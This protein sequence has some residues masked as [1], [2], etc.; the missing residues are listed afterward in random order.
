LWDRDEPRYAQCSRQMFQ[1]GDWIVP[2][3]YDAPR[4]NKPPLIYWCQAAAMRVFGHE[5]DAGAFAAR[6][7]SSLAMLCTLAILAIVITRHAGAEQ[8]FWTVLVFGSSGLTIMAA[9]VCLTDSVLLLFTMIAQLCL[10]AIW[11]GSRSWG[12]VT[13][14][15][16]ALGLGGLTKGPFIL[17]VVACTAVALAAFHFLDNFIHRRAARGDARE[18]E[19]VMA[20][21]NAGAERLGGGSPSSIDSTVRTLSEAPRELSGQGPA[22]R[23]FWLSV[24]QILLGVFIVLA[25]VVPWIL[26]VHHREPNFLGQMF[27]EAKDHLEEGKEG[28]HFPPGYHLVVV[29][30]DFMPWSLLLPMAIGIGIGNWRIPQARFA[31]AAVIGPWVMVEFIGTKLP[32]YLLPAL[33]PLAFLAAWAIRDCISGKARDMQSRLFLIGAGIWASVV[34]CVG[35]LPWWMARTFRPQPWGAMIVLT[36]GALLLAIAV[37]WLFRERRAGPALATTGLGMLALCAAA[38]TLFLPHAAYLQTSK[39][40]ANDLLKAGATHKGEVYMV[41]YKEPSLAFYQGGTLRERRR[42]FLTP[43]HRAEW[44]HWLAV[45]AD[46]WNEAAPD[47]RREYREIAREKGWAYS[48]QARVVEILVVEKIGPVKTAS[49]TAK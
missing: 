2:R 38:C 3:L 29:W 24:A 14:L 10:F 13:L 28:H 1:S 35:V 49:Q 40:V 17:G 42:E 41:D 45:T 34:A 33:P 46:A 39:R 30:L 7:P 25:I 31:L 32:H 36:L 44:P 4:I 15:A 5:G 8:A 37:Y 9:K 27:H 26:A 19:P 6:F 48:D 16:V 12:V 22:P 11:R 47:I 18:F 43:R 20:G 21:A 23:P